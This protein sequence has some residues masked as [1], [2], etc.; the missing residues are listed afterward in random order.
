MLHPKL[1]NGDFADRP[2]LELKDEPAPCEVVEVQVAVEVPPQVSYMLWHIM[3]RAEEVPA[4]G[5]PLDVGLARSVVAPPCAVTVV[6]SVTVLAVPFGAFYKFPCCSKDFQIHR[7]GALK[8]LLSTKLRRGHQGQI[9]NQYN[10]YCLHV[11]WPVAVIPIAKA[12]ALRFTLSNPRRT[13]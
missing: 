4:V 5:V 1:R 12:S 3:Q 9:Y 13:L 7:G 11:V 10:L 8:V 6:V 2:G